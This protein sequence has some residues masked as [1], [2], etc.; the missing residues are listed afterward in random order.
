[1]PADAPTNESPASAP[2]A[3]GAPEPSAPGP[4]AFT[5]RALLLGLLGAL[6]V[7]GYAYSNDYGMG[8]VQTPLA[9]NHL[10]LTIYSAFF[11]LVLLVNPL[12]RA[13]RVICPFSAGEL[14][15]ILALP[16]AAGSLPT[17]GLMR[18]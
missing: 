18:P 2:P 14:V 13:V 7:A 12:L 6:F 17:H 9:G 8:F 4:G 11:L 1:M 10:P 5:V 3:A 15:I 16:L